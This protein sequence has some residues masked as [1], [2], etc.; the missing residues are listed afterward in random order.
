VKLLLGKAS[1]CGRLLLYD[2]LEQKFASEVRGPECPACGITDAELLRSTR[3]R[4]ARLRPGE[5]LQRGGTPTATAT[6]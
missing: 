2:A 3:R 5:R 4:A 1:R 6:A